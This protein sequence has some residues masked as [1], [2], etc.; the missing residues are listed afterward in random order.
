MGFGFNGYR[1]NR[2]GGKESVPK[3]LVFG[4]LSA[5]LLLGCPLGFGLL[6]FFLSVTLLLA[7]AVGSLIAFCWFCWWFAFFAD[8]ELGKEARWRLIHPPLY[9]FRERGRVKFGVLQN[10]KQDPRAEGCH[11]GFLKH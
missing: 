7:V 6:E 4:F 11:V 3:R 2:P 5:T 8:V 10:S 1:H 9:G